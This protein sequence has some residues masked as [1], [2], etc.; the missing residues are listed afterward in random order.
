VLLIVVLIVLG[1]WFLVRSVASSRLRPDVDSPPPGWLVLPVPWSRRTTIG[2]AVV[3]VVFL[4]LA[5]Y[6]LVR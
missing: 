4:A 3:G 5:L 1:V 2:S 6:L